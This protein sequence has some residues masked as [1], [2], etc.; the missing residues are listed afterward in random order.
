[1]CLRKKY[2]EWFPPALENKSTDSTE[3]QGQ[4][5]S[6]YSTGKGRGL[7]SCSKL[8]DVFES[9]RVQTLSQRLPGY[10]LKMLYQLAWWWHEPIILDT[11]KPE[12][13]GSQVQD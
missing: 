3:T 6:A 13:R 4:Q 8:M 10:K 11:P 1:V 9:W 7:E 5:Y 12:L 2:T